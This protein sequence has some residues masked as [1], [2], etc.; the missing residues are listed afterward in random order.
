MSIAI[1]MLLRPRLLILDEPTSGLDP[2]MQAQLMEV[3][4]T[5]CVKA[6]QSSARRIRWKPCTF[7]IVRSCLAEWG[8]L[9]RCASPAIL[10]ACCQ[11]LVC[12]T[13]RTF[14][15]CCKCR[16]PRAAPIVTPGRRWKSRGGQLLLHGPWSR[17]V[18]RKPLGANFA[19]LIIKQGNIVFQRTLKKFCLAIVGPRS[20]PCCSRLG[21]RSS[22]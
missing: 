19:R 16:G 5:L 11:H 18:I 6:S 20:W 7:L 10:R 14:S 21:W 22:S 2:A 17:P 8:P 3:S 12:R 13:S 9:P 15:N 4:R 1:E